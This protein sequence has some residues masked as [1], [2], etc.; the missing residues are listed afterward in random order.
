MNQTPRIGAATFVVKG[1]QILLGRSKKLDN[2]IVIPG[3]GVKWG[4]PLQIAGRREIKEEAGIEVLMGDVLFVSE[5]LEPDDHRVIVYLL[6]QYIQGELQAGDDL[7]E[8]FW[9][10]TRELAQY[11]DEMTALTLDAIYKFSIAIRARG[12][13]SRP[14]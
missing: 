12:M 2:Q 13:T 3:G 8:V 4:E 9:A 7:S 6:A 5:L 11:Q 1:T 10:D 14:N